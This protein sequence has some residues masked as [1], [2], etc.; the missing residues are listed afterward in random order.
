MACR[1]NARCI[2]EQTVSGKNFAA[3]SENRAAQAGSIATEP[4]SAPFGDRRTHAWKS[5]QRCEDL[6]SSWG[7]S[8][9]MIEKHYGHDQIEDCWDELS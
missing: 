2:G 3:P 6:H 9:R 7:T 1:T 8:E 5:G 4:V